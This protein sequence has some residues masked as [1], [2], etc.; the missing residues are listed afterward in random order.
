MR[1]ESR[2]SYSLQIEMLH[3]RHRPDGFFYEKRHVTF[4]KRRLVLRKTTG[5]F[6]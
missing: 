6:F 5:H 3:H 1:M 4:L 2:E